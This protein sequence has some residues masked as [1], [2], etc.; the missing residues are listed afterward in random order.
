MK[1]LQIT[2]RYFPAISGAEFYIKRISE[3]FIKQNQ[4]TQ[5]LC[6][7]A[8]D[9]GGLRSP[10]R[11]S[12]NPSRTEVINGVPVDRYEVL[13]TPK[14]GNKSRK[15]IE[16]IAR[17][18][19]VAPD[20][21]GKMLANGPYCPKLIEMLTRSSDETFVHSTYIPYLTVLYGQIPSRRGIPCVCTPFFHFSNP[22]YTEAAYIEALR[23]FDQVYCC[24]DLEKQFL[25]EQGVPSNLLKRISM[26]VDVE[27]YGRAK[28]DWFEKDYDVGSP[29]VLFVGYLNFEKG[30]LTLIRCLP[31]VVKKFSDTSFVFIGPPSKAFIYEFKRLKKE[32]YEKNLIYINP[33]N[34]SGY[35]DKRKLGAFKACDIYV[36]PSRS[37]AFGIAYLEAWAAKKPVIGARSGAT[38]EV[39]QDGVTGKLVGFNDQLDL[40][41]TLLNTLARPD[42]LEAFGSRGHDEIV[43]RGYTWREVAAKI[44]NY[45]EELL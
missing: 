32:G 16:R 20:I 43:S 26:G 41:R 11:R 10:N 8:I 29:M 38:L 1:L 13:G 15:V 39:I 31:M 40:A 35:F 45:L 17:E 6:S 34:L 27:K 30:A 7:N 3:I 5:V 23:G 21:V 12:L 42:E 9:F 2:P 33:S 18:A 24:T 44:R 36:M 22:R 25:E 28:A 4:D 37:D 14:N 19:G